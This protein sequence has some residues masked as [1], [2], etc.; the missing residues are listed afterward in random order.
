[1]GTD[2]PVVHS[3]EQSQENLLGGRAGPG[4]AADRVGVRR[5]SRSQSRGQNPDRNSQ[6]DCAVHSWHGVTELSVPIWWL[7]IGDGGLPS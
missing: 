6:R 1:M 2:G 5:T 4:W 7:T 3:T